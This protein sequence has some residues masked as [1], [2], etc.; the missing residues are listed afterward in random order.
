[1]S[2]FVPGI[3]ELAGAISAQ[4]QVKG[5]LTSICRIQELERSWLRDALFGGMTANTF[6]LGTDLT[7]GW[8]WTRVNGCAALYRSGSMEQIDFENILAVSEPDAA[9][10]QP[11][12]YISHDVD[13][14]YF[15][16][17]RR[18]NKCGLQERTIVAAAKVSIKSDSSLKG[19]QPNKIFAVRAQQADSNKVKLVWFYCP[20]EQT[21]LPV[22]FRIYYDNASWQIDFENPL[23]T[24]E[25]QGRKFYS[26]ETSVLQAGDYLFAVRAEGAD[27]IEDES[28]AQFEIQL[29][30]ESPE[31]IDVLETQI[32]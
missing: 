22:C 6:K 4:S 31:P 26:Y 21:S 19:S 12:A 15:Y 8:F 11:P 29:D 2:L 1:M 17:V 16:L 9:E 32:V 7:G 10:I 13:S 24:I 28:Q 5:K 27:G 20:L 30:T 25:Y 14:T 3:V 23:A 18:F